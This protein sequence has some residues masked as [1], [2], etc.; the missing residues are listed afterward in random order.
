MKLRPARPIRPGDDLP[1]H[2]TWEAAAAVRETSA[3]FRAPAILIGETT[4]L[5]D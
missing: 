3:S 4:A 5:E 1:G 2:G